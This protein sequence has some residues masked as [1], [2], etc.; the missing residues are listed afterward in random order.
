METFCCDLETLQGARALCEAVNAKTAVIDV[1]INNAGVLEGPNRV[2]T[3]DNLERVFAVNVCAPFVIFAG[4]LPLVAASK[5]GRILNVSSIFQSDLEELDLEDLQLA[6]PGRWDRF[7]SYGSSKL[8]IAMVSRELALRLPL[9]KEGGGG[10][11][12]ARGGSGSDCSRVVVM[13]CD[14]GTVNTKMLLAGWGPCGIPLDKA[15]DEFSLTKD[16]DRARHGLYFVNC[17]PRSCEAP[18]YNDAARA[19]LW[20]R[21]EG[22][23]GVTLL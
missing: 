13:S 20:K 19:D 1:L 2:L 8:L 7:R 23:C 14:P 9:A 18:V 22:I 12:S 16:Y 15:N 5:E 10:C 11:G 4:L 3:S 6:K 21:L 17:K